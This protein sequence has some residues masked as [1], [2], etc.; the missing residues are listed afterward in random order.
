MGR[1]IEAATGK[2]RSI[3]TDIGAPAEALVNK[4]GPCPLGCGGRK[5]FRF[6]DKAGRGTWICTHCGA[7]DG[8]E[9]VKQFLGVSARDA[10]RR[11]DEVLPSAVAVAPAPE[12]YREEAR[13]KVRLVWEESVPDFKEDGPVGRY[14]K[15]RLGTVPRFSRIREH[16]GLVYVDSEKGVIGRF[17]AMVA[18][19][20]LGGSLVG[21]HRTFLDYDGR[22]AP[23]ESPKK[24]VSCASI[25][26]AAIKLGRHGA[27]LGVAEGIETALAASL[28]FKQPVWSVMN[29]SGMKSF[30][31]P[32]GI[33]HLDIYADNDENGAGQ[34]A[35]FTLMHRVAIKG[36][37]SARV[38]L[39]V[40]SGTDW[41]DVY[42]GG[43]GR[44]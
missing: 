30:L 20:E 22:K 42:G 35:A 26:G 33:D 14:L 27:T 29:T 1:T 28:L 10:L 17:P 9:F 43:R 40:E 31:P 16:P 41:A 21:L 12:R 37:I 32:E 13:A 25:A 34:L 19:I 4:H 18:A 11:I 8:T 5:S 6:D 15:R 3:L 24:I 44:G 2:W 38:H 39:P 36:R 23:V 7:G